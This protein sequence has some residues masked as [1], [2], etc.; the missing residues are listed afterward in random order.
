MNYIG[1]E[2]TFKRFM[3]DDGLGEG[4]VNNY[5]S[6]LRFLSNNKFDIDENLKDKELIINQLRQS[7]SK[8]EVYKSKRDYSNFKS[9]LT[10]Y[11]KFLNSEWSDIEVDTKDIEKNTNL[12]DTEKSTHI[13]ARIGQGKFRKDVIKLWKKCSV[14]ECSKVEFLIASHI[15]PWRVSNN[16]DRLNPYNSLLL[17][18]NYDKLFDKGYISFDE[19]GSIILS[20]KIEKSVYESL[21]VKESDKLTKVFD[22]NKIFLKRHNEYFEDILFPL[23]SPSQT[24][25]P[26]NNP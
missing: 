18:P 20:N 23:K 10:K 21:G 2:T 16:H 26:Y 4:T 6:W 8:R 17:T 3:E 25:T 12:N 24:P 7:E 13:K 11:E 5:I 9:A 22:K 14:T 19:K 1:N 15:I